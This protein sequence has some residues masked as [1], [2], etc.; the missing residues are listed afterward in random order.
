MAGSQ[1]AF[2]NVAPCNLV[3]VTNIWEVL[4]ASTAQMMEAAKTSTKLKCGNTPE[5]SHLQHNFVFL[6]AS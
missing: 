6:S 3:V 1:G 4:A 2:W 5:D